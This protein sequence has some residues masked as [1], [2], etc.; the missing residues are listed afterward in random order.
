[1]RQRM[2]EA[3]D[4]LWILDLEGDNLGARKT[5]NVFA[6][7]TPVCIATGI[8]Q[9]VKKKHVLA[10]VRYARLT[11]TRQEKLA[12]LKAIRCFGDVAWEDCFDG[13]TEP[14]LPKRVG[15]LLRMA[16]AHGFVA[17]AALGSAM[18]KIMANWR[19]A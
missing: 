9:A 2:R 13:A 17:V 18:E 5:E 3:F 15:K 6:I 7:Q 12:K 4:E 10:K 19:D 11:G 8:R 1:M 16:A 14:M